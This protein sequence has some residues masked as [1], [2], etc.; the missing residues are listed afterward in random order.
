MNELKFDVDKWAEIM[1]KCDETLKNMCE[2]V[3]DFEKELFINELDKE[4][5]SRNFRKS[6]Y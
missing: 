3:K 4:T 6:K 5:S 1:S 2:K